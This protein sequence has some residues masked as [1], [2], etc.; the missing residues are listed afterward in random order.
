VNRKHIAN[1]IYR[2]LVRIKF[3]PTMA[4]DQLKMIGFFDGVN[5][6]VTQWSLGRPTRI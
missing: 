4:T 6:D 3:E 5:V 2:G 1:G